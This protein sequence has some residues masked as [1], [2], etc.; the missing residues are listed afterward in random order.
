MRYELAEQILQEALAINEALF[1]SNH[2]ETSHTLTRLGAVFIHNGKLQEAEHVLRQSLKI[3]EN[4]LGKNH[5]RVGQTLKHLLAVYEARGDYVTAEEHG[6]RALK[7][8][9]DACGPFDFHVSSIVLKMGKCS[10]F[11]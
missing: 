4:S 2:V 11:F 5:S 3:R 7:I 10:S 8:T 6:L 9:E 1:G